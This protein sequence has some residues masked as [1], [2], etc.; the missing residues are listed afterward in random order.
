MRHSKLIRICA[1]LAVFALV[2]AACGDGDTKDPDTPEGPKGGI[3]RVQVDTDFGFNGGFDPSG[4]YLGWAWDLYSNLLIRN[5]VTYTHTSGARGAEVVAD[6]ATEIPEPSEDGLVYE[7][8]LKDDVK[9]GPPLNRDIVAQDFVTAFK[10]I[11]TASVAAQY[12]FYYNGVIKGLTEFGALEVAEQK[13]A[14]IPGVE[15]VDDKTLKITLEKPTGDLMFRLAMPATAPFPA[16]VSDC[17][18]KAGEYGRYVISSGPYMIQGSDELDA[19]SCKTMKPISGFDPTERLAFVR[20]PNYNGGEAGADPTDSFEVRENNVDGL[21]FTVNTNVED[22]FNK[23]E[24][25]EIEGEVATA[26]PQVLQKY[27]ESSEFK[28]RLKVFPG[29]RTWYVTMNLTLP[30]FD[31]INMRKAVNIAIDKDQ[32]RRIRGGPL[33]GVIATHVLPP[34]MT[35]GAPTNTDLDPYES[36]ADF[37]GDIEAAKEFVKQSK[38]D[39]D[40]DGECDADVCKDVL[41]L[42]RNSSPQV[43][44]APAIEESLAPLGLTFN[45]RE[46]DTGTAYAQVGDIA[47]KFPIAVNAGWGKDYSDPSTFMVLFDGRNISCT[48]GANSNYALVGLT[49]E[50]AAECGIAD[51][52]ERNIEGVPNV[53]ADIDECSALDGQERTDCWVALDEKLMNEVVMWAPMLWATNNDLLGPAVA[54]YDFDQFA[55]EAAYSKV[56]VDVS[57]QQGKTELD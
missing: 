42:T 9:F 40:Q 29:D 6:L 50:K 13:T 32:L 17:F 30:P 48:A 7:F 1:V 22:I 54:K 24:A 27:S 11:G 4:E 10:R 56:A 47:K 49:A 2:G 26:P 41:F 28:D 34:E 8:T 36:N 38:Y 45:I 51:D 35:G 43:D 14:N 16:E 39:S 18:V 37:T 52:P 57:K 15:A 25:G 5:L 46:L 23:I 44:Q 20:N 19:T 3:Y 21:L 55:G 33:T 12:G 53:D 31:D